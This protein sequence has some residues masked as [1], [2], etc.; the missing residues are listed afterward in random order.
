MLVRNFF[1]RYNSSFSFML[2]FM[3]FGVLFSCE[4]KQKEPV[5]ETEKVIIKPSFKEKVAATNLENYQLLE[6]SCLY[7]HTMKD[8]EKKTLTMLS[9]RSAYI[10][11]YT[12]KSDFV[13]AFVSLAQE[14]AADSLLMKTNAVEQCGLMEKELEHNQKDIEDLAGFLFDYKFETHP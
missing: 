12:L 8:A 3:F 13:H 7:C 2:I 4:L 1:I 11:T 9:I 6:Y 5:K 14:A 10:E